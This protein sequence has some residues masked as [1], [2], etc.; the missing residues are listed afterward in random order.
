MGCGG[1]N[2]KSAPSTKIFTWTSADGK[3]TKSY[4][5]EVQ[6]RLQVAKHKGSFR[7]TS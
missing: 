3:Q 4:S 5:S 6:A 2:G 1:C 7:Q